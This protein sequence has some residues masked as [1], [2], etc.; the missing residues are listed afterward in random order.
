MVDLMRESLLQIT[1]PLYALNQ[2]FDQAD[3]LAALQSLLIAFFQERLYPRLTY[4]PLM[5]CVNDKPELICSNY[6]KEWLSRYRE[7][8]YVLSD[9]QM[10]RMK[11]ETLPFKWGKNYPVAINS[12]TQQTILE[13]SYSYG[14]EKGIMIPIRGK[15]SSQ[16]F[17]IATFEGQDVDLDDNFAKNALILFTAAHLFHDY[18]DPYFTYEQDL[19]DQE[20][21]ELSAKQ[22]E[23]LRLAALGKSKWEISMI[24]GMSEAT[25]HYHLRE[26]GRRL[27]THGV[28][29]TVAKAMALGYIIL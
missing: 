5:N 13:E 7:K 3:S 22:I 15:F 26:V 29:A 6:P 10:L 28:T 24:I 25:V 8:D 20:V 9:P 21:L 12:K 2:R 19:N 16:A 17:L 11:R 18:M 23:I 4:S 1:D 27:N 14:H